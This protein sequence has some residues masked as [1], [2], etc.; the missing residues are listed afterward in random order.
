MEVLD[1]FIGIIIMIIINEFIASTFHCFLLNDGIGAMRT[2][3][4]FKVIDKWRVS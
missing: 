3:K 1:G 4:S 2:I